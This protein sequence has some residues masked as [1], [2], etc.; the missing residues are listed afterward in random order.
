VAGPLDRDALDGFVRDRPLR[1]QHRSGELWL[2]NGAACQAVGLD[3]GAT[4]AAT[5]ERDASG[6]ATGRLFR[7]D[8]W[9]R[10]RLPRT[11]APKLGRI[12][13]ALAHFGVTGVTDASPENGAAELGLFADAM[14][15]GELPQ[16][17]VAMGRADLPESAAPRL[18][19]GAVK[20]RLSENALPS[21]D[22]V[23]A[24]IG[25]AHAQQRGMALH[26]VT[27]A[28]LVFAA[29]AFAAAGARPEDRIEH[30]SLA[31]PDTLALLAN[32]PLHVVTQPGFVASRGDAY[33]RDVPPED[34]PH[35]Y[36]CRGLLAAGIPLGG[37]TDAPFGDPDP[38]ASLRA[39][40]D[41]TTAQGAVLGPQEA[42]DPEQALALF[43]SPL[44]AP[45][46]PPRRLVPGAPADLCLLDRPWAAARRQLESK[47]VVAT[48]CAGRLA[49]AAWL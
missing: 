5:I 22:E 17:V 33:R 24:A 46:A 29:A 3:A 10:E 8:A 28:E 2:L 37:S 31:P 27:R 19:R 26:C 12:G 1:I 34:H 7:S 15:R 38:W 45:G 36:R 43:T 48:W 42:L 25:S 16:R 41:R 40:V 47:L 20:L 35:L 32:L 6:R 9:L 21:F 44:E 13:S 23:V 49:A 39:A 30:A 18:L 4:S 11:E 14:A